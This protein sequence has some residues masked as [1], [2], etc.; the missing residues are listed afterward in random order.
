MTQ[1]QTRNEALPTHMEV[2]T[3][4][5]RDIIFDYL[6]DAGVTHL[7][8][9]PGTNEIPLIDGTDPKAKHHITYVECLHENIALGAAAGYAREAGVPGVVQLHV[10]PGIAH[11]VGNLFNAHRSHV[12]LLVL[13]GQQH[14]NLLA[15]EP[16][17][18]SDLVRIAEQYTKW[19]YEVRGPDEIGLAMQRALKTSLAPPMGPVFLSIPWEF[20]VQEGVDPNQGKFTRIANGFHGDTAEVDKAA[21][22]LANPGN[23]VIIVGDG[24]GEAGAWE[25]MTELAK[26]IGAPVYSEQL[27]SHL[28]YPNHGPGFRG[29]LPGI[30]Q[31]IRQ[32]LSPYDTVF[33]CGFNSQA[34]LVIYDW[35][36]GPLIPGKLRQVY[37]HNNPWEIGKNYRADAAVLGDIKTTLPSLTRLTLRHQSNDEKR[38]VLDRNTDIAATDKEL[39]EAFKKRVEQAKKKDSYKKGLDAALVAAELHKALTNKGK[40]L[41]LVN[42]TVSDTAAF[43]MNLPFDAPAAYMAAEGGSLG[44]SMPAGIGVAHA[45]HNSSPTQEA[46]PLVVNAVGDGSALFYLHSW[47]TVARHRLPVLY[48]ILNNRQYKTL[49]IGLEVLKKTYKWNPSGDAN[50]LKLEGQPE[51]SFVA[52]AK[53]FGIQGSPPVRNPMELTKAIRK[54]VDEVSAGKPYVVEILSNR[55]LPKVEISPNGQTHALQGD[56]GHEKLWTFGPA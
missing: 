45:V 16:L 38:D 47:W 53:D 39:R 32:V 34:Q 56:H 27:S 9:V 7:F 6:K 24:V 10:T 26:A 23:P 22:I 33:V 50:Y 49:R 2:G 19:S 48:L 18:A 17:L 1:L 4:V 52:L 3:K 51:I 5:T 41:R 21:R 55:E 30:Q 13:C 54:G 25:E 8:G 46:R 20:L 40:M 37:L 11:A 14:S 12:P 36:E 43:Q 44:Y 31:Q 15:Q 35:T 42:E 29:E 28:N